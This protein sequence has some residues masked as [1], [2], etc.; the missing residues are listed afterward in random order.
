MEGVGGRV[1]PTTARDATRSLLRTI[2][3][4]LSS[5]MRVDADIYFVMLTPRKLKKAMLTTLPR[6]TARM[7]ARGWR[8]GGGAKLER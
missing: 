4:R 6:L 2:V 3:R 8:W 1:W 7:N 5:T